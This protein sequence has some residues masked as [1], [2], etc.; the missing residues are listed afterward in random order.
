MQADSSDM[1]R[2]RC[3]S[4]KHHSFRIVGVDDGALPSRRDADGHALLAAVVLQGSRIETI[5]AG[6][7]DVDGTDANRV[8]TALFRTMRFDIAMLS[9]ISFGGFNLADIKDLARITRK[10]V[11]AITGERPNNKAVRAALRKHFD[12]WKERCR[13]VENA[14]KLYSCKPLTNEPE[15]YFEVKGGSAA[16][17]KNAIFSSATISRLPEPIRVAGIVARSLAPL[18]S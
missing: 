4:T 8:L 11:I 3:K 12:D 5:R 13:M 16:L 10:P 6:S 9:G 14:G 15:L 17:A 18:L 1:Y 2:N 7:I